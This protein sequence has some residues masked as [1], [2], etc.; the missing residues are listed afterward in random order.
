MMRTT[1]RPDRQA[2]ILRRP[3]MATTP[4]SAGYSQEATPLACALAAMLQAHRHALSWPTGYRHRCRSFGEFPHHSA[5]CH[6]HD[7]GCAFVSVAT[8]RVS[9]GAP[10][11]VELITNSSKLQVASG[12][13]SGGNASNG[14]GGT[15]WATVSVGEA[16][17]CQTTGRNGRWG[18]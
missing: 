7:R 4:P 12:A 18:E 5:L 3:P 1:D 8:F 16:E 15:E 11:A 14:H 10:L 2:T 13:E 17:I 9:V 6:S